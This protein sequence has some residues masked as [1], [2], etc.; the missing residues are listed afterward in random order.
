MTMCCGKRMKIDRVMY[1][2]GEGDAEI[3]M[4][5]CVVCRTVHVDIDGFTVEAQR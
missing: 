2:F 1:D 3:E 4:E 5:F